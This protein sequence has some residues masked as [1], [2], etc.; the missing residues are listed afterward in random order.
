MNT[1]DHLI[2]KIKRNLHLFNKPGV[3]FVRPGFCQKNGWPT[4][5]EA[6]VAVTSK[7]SRKVKLPAAV[8]GTPVEVRPAS[9]LEQLS[10]DKPEQFS[11]AADHRAE[12]RG[13]A[14]PEFSPS[15]ARVRPKVAPKVSSSHQTKAQISYTPAN[16][17]LRPVAGKIRITC[18]VSPDAG[19][20]TLRSFVSATKKQLKVS[21]YDFTS[22]HVLNLF[23]QQLK[24]DTLQ[25]TLDDP[26]K[27]PSA[28]QT[29]P[30]TIASLKSGLTS[31]SSA[32]ALV[33]ASP[34][35][36]TWIFPTAYH[37][38]VMVRDSETVWLSSGNLNNSNQPDIDPIGAPKASDQQ[39]AKASDRDWHVIIE[40][41]QLASIF[42][43]Y[44]DHDF[45]Q[46]T[47]HAA[48]GPATSKQT[49]ASKASK[50]PPSTP[51]LPSLNQPV[52]GTFTFVAPLPVNEQMTITPLLTPDQGDYQA[53]MLAL[54][55]SVQS[56]LY[57]QLQ[58]IHPTSVAADSAF[59]DLIDAVAA[60]INAGKDV[61]IILSQFQVPKG[62]LDALQ[63]AGI[64]LN[65]VRIQNRVHNK[66]FV[67]DHKKVVVSSMNWSGEGVL[68]NRDA[69]VI[70]DNATAAAYYEKVFLDDWA[71]HATQ[72][73]GPQ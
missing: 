20:P 23:R 39:T 61:R 45:Q 15:L 22:A 58:Y 40:S 3:L 10:H 12:L 55:N 72:D 33:R 35:A 68:E 1:L 70:I 30:Q 71:H 47:L 29:D 34:E 11:S 56:S 19:W 64:N 42:E 53:A 66:G 57:M 26:P 14:L 18:H 8:E 36:D 67:F 21:M 28:N 16:V 54:I 59:T 52:T 41:P 43:A 17:A 25:L 73:G 38:K 60:K 4:K 24:G 50:A 65:N 31:F 37:I 2:P 9:D 13:S 62:G 32:W 46:A 69:G 27:N 48:A 51:N 49:K 7:K 44:L 6:I 5:E 63:A